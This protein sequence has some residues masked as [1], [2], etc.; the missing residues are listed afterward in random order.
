MKQSHQ[1]VARACLLAVALAITGCAATGGAGDM[2]SDTT[3]SS[4][5]DVA[6]RGDVDRI[7]TS[8]AITSGSAGTSGSK[9]ATDSGGAVM[10]DERGDQPSAA[11][12]RTPAPNGTVL[13]IAAP[14]AE[15]G[16]STSDAS[17]GASG[18]AG[19]S[20]SG[21]GDGGQAYRVMVRMDDGSTQ[22][23]TYTGTPDF[24]S[25]ERINVTGGAIR[26]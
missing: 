12:T 4:T 9:G 7:V 26:R 17:M 6:S 5:D 18:T 20:G 23:I 13:S 8:P 10:Q 15:N 24:R 25:G 2:Y 19:T 11:A 16:A 14:A 21:D 1:S 3:S 22:A